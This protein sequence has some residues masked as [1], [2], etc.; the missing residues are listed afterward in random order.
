[1]NNAFSGLTATSRS[2]EV[3]SN[4][5]SNVL[6]DGFARREIDVTSHLLNGY[7]SGVSIEGVRRAEDVIA[8]S[9][10]RAMDAVNAYNTTSMQSS[11]RMSSALGEPGDAGALANLFTSF[12]SAITAAA[13]DPAS[14]S[15]QLDVIAKA[16]A[17]INSFN[18]IS[19]NNA[20]IR[21]DADTEIARQVDTLNNALERVHDLNLEIRS[22]VNG[23]GDINALVDTRQKLIDEI[24][25][26]VPV[27]VVKREHGQVALFTP[28]GGTLL[29]GRVTTFDF[30]PTGTITHAMTLGL[31]SLS[32]L[33]VNGTP[34]PVGSGIGFFDGG[35]L[36]AL[37][38]TRDVDVPAFNAQVDA[39]AR[40]L[41]ERFQD[42]AVD[43]TLLATDAGL[44]TDGGAFFSVANENG[45]AGRLSLNALAD[46]A[47]G[48]N[49]WTLRD[50]L[51]AVAQGPAGL[52]TIFRNLEAALQS[53]RAP[54]ANMG[55]TAS[56][57]ASGFAS[58]L[59]S[60]SAFAS[61]RA[62]EDAAFSSAELSSLREAET[63]RIG[64][65]SDEQ[66]Q[67][68]LEIEKA[69]AANAR[70]MSVIDGLLGQLLEI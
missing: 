52:N 28:A 23:S 4:N 11:N 39:L 26:I 46:P 51:N 58:E 15:L 12:E 22:R 50:G 19:T 1:M 29:D 60:Q 53:T 32:G 38:N 47:Q 13:G 48:G 37:F 65:D 61:A 70:V 18:A 66:M 42:P 24:G 62:D 45:L 21:V 31:G 40:D 59:T 57:S 35:S 67:R 6:T 49:A 54:S 68:L 8:T 7:G 63:S 41:V 30:S 64:V 25:Q 55:I 17:L 69:Y 36:E 33:D 5:I 20:Q 16:N 56:M 27:N 44:F 9:S 10:R 3:V 2:A 14:N 34:T 43:P